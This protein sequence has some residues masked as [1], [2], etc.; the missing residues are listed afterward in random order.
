MFE[1]Q[2]SHFSDMPHCLLSLQRNQVSVAPSGKAPSFLF[3]FMNGESKIQR[4]A[5]SLGPEGLFMTGIWSLCL[6]QG[7]CRA[8]PWEQSGG[9]DCHRAQL[10]DDDWL[11]KVVLCYLVSFHCCLPG[12]T[13]VC[14]EDASLS[15]FVFGQQK[16]CGLGKYHRWADFLHM[17]VLLGCFSLDLLEKNTP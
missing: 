7:S 1:F 12:C 10:R 11:V 4:Q 16:T 14:T 15:P 17:V 2:A 5:T 13:S 9:G 8:L 3:W 6:S